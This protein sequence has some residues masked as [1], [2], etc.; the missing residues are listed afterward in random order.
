GCGE[1]VAVLAD[2]I[3]GPEARNRDV[4]IDAVGT[5]QVKGSTGAVCCGDELEAF[6]AP[7]LQRRL[8]GDVGARTGIGVR[9]ANIGPC[10]PRA[11]LD[12][13][14]ETSVFERVIAEPKTC[15]GGYGNRH[16]QAEDKA[17]GSASRRFR[18][19]WL[20]RLRLFAMTRL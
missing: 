16:Q 9:R 17:H 5:G 15:T 12:G 7:E 3:E 14:K 10:A 8:A 6:T 1:V 2:G 4:A 11:E 18:H 19:V 13:A 20:N